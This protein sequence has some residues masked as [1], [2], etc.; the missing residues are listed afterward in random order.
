MAERMA[1]R[2]AKRM[3]ERSGKNFFPYRSPEM[4]FKT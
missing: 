2:M 1:K 4:H 3:A